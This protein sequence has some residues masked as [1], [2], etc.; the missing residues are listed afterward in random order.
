MTQQTGKVDEGERG[1]NCWVKS[2]RRKETIG[3]QEQLFPRGDEYFISSISTGVKVGYVSFDVVKW[4]D[5]VV[6]DEE[7]Q[8]FPK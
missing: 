2:L 1:G 3:Y 4:I 5:P 6:E 7:F 8:V